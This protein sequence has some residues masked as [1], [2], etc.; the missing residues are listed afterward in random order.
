MPA[1]LTSAMPRLGGSGSLPKRQPSKR[2]R[3]MVGS[4]K[5][6]ARSTPSLHT[7]NNTITKQQ[8]RRKSSLYLK[9]ATRPEHH[10]ETVFIADPM[11]HNLLLHDDNE[12]TSEDAAV[13]HVVQHTKEELQFYLAKIQS[14]VKPE[15]I[16]LPTSKWSGYKNGR[17]LSLS[18]S[19]AGFDT[20]ST[21]WSQASPSARDKKMQWMYSDENPAVSPI[22]GG[23]KDTYIRQ[24]LL[25]SSAGGSSVA[26]TASTQDFTAKDGYKL[27]KANKSQREYHN[28]VNHVHE[29]MF[30][31]P[32]QSPIVERIRKGLAEDK[33]ILNIV[34]QRK[35]A[36]LDH[37]SSL[38]ASQRPTKNG[39]VSRDTLQRELIRLDLSLKKRDVDKLL[40]STQ[41]LDVNGNVDVQKLLANNTF[42]VQ[43]TDDKYGGGILK[44]TLIPLQKRASSDISKQRNMR[45]TFLR[46]IVPDANTDAYQKNA[47]Q[48]EFLHGVGVNGTKQR[49]QHLDHVAHREKTREVQHSARISSEFIEREQKDYARIEAIRETSKRYQS[50]LDK[51]T[52]RRAKMGDR[53]ALGQYKQRNPQRRSNAH[54]YKQEIG[55]FHRDRIVAEYNKKRKALNRQDW[56]RIFR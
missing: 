11:K 28:P 55:G 24:R 53:F 16:I 51:E 39:S 7:N 6:G 26:S 50:F 43:K 12:Q 17:P 2:Q 46:T 45:S 5:R 35:Q 33:R 14:G 36:I 30:M 56:N 40:S 4:C 34:R 31:P 25:G 15:P 22:R 54:Q 41:H 21:T 23:A 48:R 52:L 20:A 38:P 27:R 10:E 29:Q 49:Q 47:Y 9:N 13:P 1:S 42:N 19:T 3:V 8:R 32:E 44:H 18:S 37:L